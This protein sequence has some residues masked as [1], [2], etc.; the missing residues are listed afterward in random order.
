M[1]LKPSIRQYIQELTKDLYKGYEL[2]LD[3]VCKKLEISNFI[4][5][6]DES[7]SGV[8]KKN[9]QTGGYEAYVNRRHPQ[10]R[11]RFTLAHELGHYIS[12]KYDSYSKKELEQ[13][14]ALADYA[15]SYRKDGVLSDAETE[16][17]LIAAT[18]LMPQNKVQEL[19]EQGLIIEEM[20]EKFFVSPS[21]MTI[22]LQNL[23]PDLM[24]I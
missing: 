11:R 2:Q 22:R 13:E 19:Q 24:V 4:A 23:Y 21:A 16:A 15:M 9:D 10:S 17:N 14:G 12:F 1:D 8:L 3:S 18:M 6:F 5:D 7:I 20:A